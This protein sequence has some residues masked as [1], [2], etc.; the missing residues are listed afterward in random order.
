MRHVVM[1]SFT[2]T[3]TPDQRA[4]AVQA[5]R[6]LEDAIPFVLDLSVETDLGLKDG[7]ADVLLTIEFASADD[8]RAY[9]EHPAH[10]AVVTEH[11]RPILKSGT[12]IQV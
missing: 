5:L 3:A 12:F 8:W 2:D 9:S 11:V 1:L 7:N 10:V 6:S 4:A